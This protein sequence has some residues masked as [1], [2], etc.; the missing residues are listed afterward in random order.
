MKPLLHLNQ[1]GVLCMTSLQFSR[2]FCVTTP[3]PLRVLSDLC[4]RKRVPGMRDVSILKSKPLPPIQPLTNT[5]ESASRNRGKIRGV[6]SD[7][8]VTNPNPL[9]VLS[10]LCVS[11]LQFLSGLSARKRVPG[12]RDV[13]ILKSKLLPPIQPLTNTRE[14][15]S[16]NR[17]KIRGVLSGLCVSNP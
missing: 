11:S 9:R 1:R 7:L 15:A 16:C 8:C 17:G 5:R 13:S 14:S 4:A 6:L 3:N 12:T 2:A 10:D